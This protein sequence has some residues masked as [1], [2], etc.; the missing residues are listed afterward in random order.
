MERQSRQPEERVISK[1]K[2]TQPPPQPKNV[3]VRISDVIR[4]VKKLRKVL[5]SKVNTQGMTELTPTDIW[6]HDGSTYCTLVCNSRTLAKKLK[7]LL[8]KV[9]GEEGRSEQVDRT[10]SQPL[11][12]C[13]FDEFEPPK[14]QR[15]RKEK[16][17]TAMGQEF[18]RRQDP[19]LRVHE[20][21]LTQTGKDIDTLNRK[22]KALTKLSQTRESVARVKE[23]LKRRFAVKQTE[24]NIKA[25]ED[26][27]EELQSQ[28]KTFM[29]AL[30]GFRQQ[31]D[32]LL[33]EDDYEGKAE[34]VL[35][36]LEVECRRL[37]RALPMYARRQ[38]IVQLVQQHSVS[39]LQAETGSGKSTQVVQYLMDAGF[40]ERG[41]IVCTQPH[42]MAAVSL[43]THVAQEMAGEVGKDVGYKVGSRVKTS[44][45][46][47]VIFMTNQALLNECLT[48][49]GLKAFSCVVVDE[50]HERRLDTDLLLSM[51]KRCLAQNLD[52][53]VVIT[54]ATIDPQVFVDFFNKCKVMRIGG[55]TFPVDV[56][57]KD[58]ASDDD[59]FDNYVEAAVSKAMQIHQN[60]PS[61]DI[62]VFLTSP[63]EIKKSCDLLQQRLEDRTDFTCLQ[64]HGRLQAE[65]QQRVLQPLD[66]SKRKIV[67]ATNCAETSIT[68][69]GI[70]YVV[71][72]GV[73]KEPRYDAK[74]NIRS[75]KVG[76]VSRSS[77]EQ[78][79]GRAG[80]TEPGTC[81]RLYSQT[82]FQAMDTIS[83]PEI[84]NTHLGQALLKLAELGVTPDKYDFV[85][86]PGQ[87]AIDAAL[88]TLSQLGALSDGEITD[89][90]R[91]I[92]RLPFDPRLGILIFRCRGQGL[93]YD[94]IVLAA[95]VSAGSWLFY[96]GQTE[97]GPEK[98]DSC[99][100][101]FSHPGGDCLA[102]LE[103]YKAWQAVDEERKS[104]WCVDNFVD[105]K[106]IC[107]VRDTVN[108]VCSLL[109]N[110][111]NLE[112]THIFSEAPDTPD[113]LRKIVFRCN[114]S[115]LCYYLGQ[116]RVGY[117]AAQAGRQ[118]H[119]HPSSTLSSQG[120]Y[121]QWVVYDQLEQMSRDFIIGITPVDDAWLR[122][123][124][125]E[126]LGFDVEEVR[127]IEKKLEKVFTQPA[128]SYAFSALVGPLYTKLHQLRECSDISDSSMVFAEASREAGEVRVYS[129]DA[130]CSVEN[131]TRNLTE[132]VNRAAEDVQREVV[133]LVVGS[134]GS[135][136]RVVLGP[137]AQVID[138]LMPHETRK[139]FIN[140]PSK[141][142]SQQTLKQKFKR[143][144]EVCFCCPYS[145]SEL[146]G[147][148]LFQKKSEA[149]KAAEATKNDRENVAILEQPNS[150]KQS[151]RFRARL[152]CNRRFA[153]GCAFVEVS[154][155]YFSKC[156]GIKSLQMGGKN[157]RIEKDLTKENSLLLTNLPADVTG[158]LIK[159]ELLLTLGEEQTAPDILGTVIVPHED[160][161][162]DKTPLEDQIQKEFQEHLTSSTVCVSLDEPKTNKS[163]IFEG[164]ALFSDSTEGLA[165]CKKLQGC[166]QLS[167]RQRV[168]V[169]PIISA[170]LRVP[171]RVYNVCS[172]QLDEVIKT[173]IADL[174]VD[175]FTKQV[176]EDNWLI[177]LKAD[178]ID[179]VI[180]AKDCLSH[181][182][183]GEV[184]DC[185]HSAVLNPLLTSAGRQMLSETETSAYVS[186]DSRRKTISIH[187]P[188]EARK[189]GEYSA[190][191]MTALL[192]VQHAAFI[193]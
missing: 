123:M 184:L 127:Q 68:I 69:D 43:A 9:D 118:V 167:N 63:S 161:A 177:L 82:S 111:E 53:R 35:K 77:A 52:L 33:T 143:F 81:Y 79:K 22:L 132:V 5:T 95:L 55:R 173:K 29:T 114:V 49:P 80:R 2:R 7:N 88:K 146:W 139:V 98:L 124:S 160:Q 135:G 6:I 178:D 87:D 13:S 153:K 109:K 155:T 61:G 180:Q 90:G 12:D 4:D 62:L 157:V 36:R 121:P 58:S 107:A 125:K 131:L 76:A 73:V 34:S 70:K 66:G 133:E 103:V 106:V 99:K 193:T 130:A 164:E 126:S 64:L 134:Q 138:I 97:A 60:K 91:W 30:D 48:D 46:T 16:F 67:F 171:E 105:A 175:V 89:A 191:S 108:D 54:S 93:L 129:T 1:S 122:E 189:K 28:K 65:E 137:G 115:N 136:V 83:Q 17:R 119:F 188:P 24:E 172:E 168:S 152:K 10:Q 110:K 101:K 192:V 32:L 140:N 166:I 72:T 57:W 147:F 149:V 182:T 174:R 144:G 187:G 8:L 21:K 19:A 148:L 78:R 44:S 47:K 102:S 165:A 75:L 27:L 39:V 169:E 154:P 162:A 50:A 20:E 11:I 37:E 112:V 145:D 181:V 38:D 183:K 15:Q 84:L 156:P 18:D 120:S 42:E 56:E 71:D 142:V 23:K 85:Q 179:N 151:A 116:E 59:Q 190:T 45:S 92:A 41:T 3:Y 31:L 117:L 185:S 159:R 74:R 100:V 186:V 128:G 163:V 40:G 86:H 113:A 141:D 25:L 51:V 158:D 26:K 104:Q 170:T 176:G 96:T 150:A 14:A 94:G